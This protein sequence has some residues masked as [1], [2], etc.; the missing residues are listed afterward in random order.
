ME[1]FKWYSI[2]FLLFIII[3]NTINIF[4]KEELKGKD[5]WFITMIPIL[6]YIL[7]VSTTL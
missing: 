5:F 1:I 3:G 4:T 2:I 6:M 7:L